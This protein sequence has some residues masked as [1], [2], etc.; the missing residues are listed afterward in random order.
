MVTTQSELKSG[1]EE[2]LSGWKRIVVLGIGNEFG[3]DDSLGLLAAKK[4]KE[5][6][7]DIPEV[8]VLAAGN[9]PENFT[10]LLR[11]FS[12]SHVLFVDAAE[13]GERAGTIKL[14]EAHEIEEITPSTHSLPLHLL[15]NYLEQELGSKMIILGIQPKKL[16]FGTSLSTEV[17]DSI[18]KLVLMLEEILTNT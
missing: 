9:A 17:K 14:I 8:Q 18:N 1:V 10:G 4:L 5:S 15:A 3:G 11:N 6:L 2:A 16:Y 12:P 7:A 13:T